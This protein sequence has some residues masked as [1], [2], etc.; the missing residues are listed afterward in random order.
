M[1]FILTLSDYVYTII[2]I[3]SS[4][5]P[6]TVYA[7]YYTVGFYLGMLFSI[8]WAS[9]MAFLVYKSLTKPESEL[10]HIF[11]KALGAVFVLATIITIV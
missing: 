10:K 3:A 7:I 2:I 11:M 6:S 5:Y 8:F 1:V 4:L 9:V